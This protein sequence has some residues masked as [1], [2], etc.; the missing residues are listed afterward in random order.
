MRT[1][2]Q[3]LR[4]GLRMLGKNPGF[5]AVAVLTLAL[6]IGANTAIFSVVNAVLLR[7]LPY[8]D[9]NRL[10]FVWQTYRPRGVTW[11]AVA[12]ANFL[13][14]RE[15]NRVFEDMAA[16]AISGVYLTGTGE[17]KR[18]EGQRVSAS[19]FPL[20][21]VSPLLGRT[22]LA[23]EDRPGGDPVVILSHRLW[24]E[25]FGAD[26]SAIG[27]TLTLDGEMHTVVGIMPPSF[28]FFNGWGEG[29]PADLWLPYPFKGLPPTQRDLCFFQ[30]IARLR[31]DVSLAQAQVGMETIARR[32]EAA[33]PKAN[34]GVG[35]NV[36]PMRKHLVRDVRLSLLVLIGA[37]GFVLLIACANVANLLLAR[38]AARQK[39]IAIRVAVGAGRWRVVRQ[40]LTETV[41][42]A[43]LGGALGLLVAAWGIEALVALSPGN[44]PRLDEIGIDLRVLGFTF[45]VALVTG[46]IFGLAP[47]IGASKVNLSESLKEAARHAGEGFRSRRLRSLLVVSEVALALVLLCGAGLLINSFL[48]LRTVNPGFNP[49]NILTVE[50]DLPKTKYFD[51]TGIG[52]RE[53]YDKGMKLWTDRPQRAAFI[54]EVVQRLKALPGVV[55][56]AKI[57]YI[58]VLGSAGSYFTIEGRP[59][60]RPK[61]MPYAD[62]LTIT[63][64]YFRTMGIRL[65]KGHLFTEQDMVEA[66][67]MAVIDETLARR[68]F[69]NEDPIGKRLKADFLTIDPEDI[70]EAGAWLYEIVG[71][72]GSVR[73]WGLDKDSEPTMYVPEPQQNRTDAECWM[74]PRTRVSFV[75]RTASEPMSLAAAARKAVWEVDPDQP[76]ESITTMEQSVSDTLKE[77]RFYLLLL[78]IF[79]AVALILATVGI[80]GVISYSIAQRTHEIGVRMALGAA[81]R[82]V[83]KLVV[84]QG[85]ILVLIGVAVGLAG[86]FGL[87]RFLAGFLYGVRPTDPLTLVGVSVLL[88]GVALLACY[89][90]ARRATKV[91]PMVALRY[92]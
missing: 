60:V 15:Q 69:P 76:I 67:G 56:A 72:V 8:K 37:V 22:F 77:R 42:L 27:K 2:L 87:T 81:R 55:S 43:L 30:V 53:S 89:I 32:L 78:G 21:G 66:P 23:E 51:V 18:L 7:P 11:T 85:M 46:L 45:L 39:E 5:T 70:V 14:W 61:E 71:V 24:Q 25:R 9:P 82:D 88:T 86:A 34:K 54:E 29:K 13:D 26:P 52:T 19:L 10:V 75:I 74:Q 16:V 3:D 36:I 90:P 63:P 50:V 65:V 92:E 59:P 58:P 80:Y 33:Y 31:P 79:A 20:L 38:A 6:G 35:V 57:N 83:L 17:P 48:R 49:E 62:F 4:Y 68:Y 64:A 40:L 84:G 12:P 41:L 28:R 1:L 91:D 73:E 44:L 47:A